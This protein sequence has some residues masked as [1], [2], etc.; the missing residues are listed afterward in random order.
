[1]K[2]RG[3]EE[4]KLGEKNSRLICCAIGW[5]EVDRNPPI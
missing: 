5:L 2:S 4:L 3:L 1:M